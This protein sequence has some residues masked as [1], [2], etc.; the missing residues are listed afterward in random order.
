MQPIASYLIA[1]THL[2]TPY[3]HPTNSYRGR[4]WLGVDKE[5]VS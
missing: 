1:I 2:S 3:Q 4:S 5:M